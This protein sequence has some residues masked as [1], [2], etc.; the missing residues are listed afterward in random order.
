MP[1]FK[2][3][4]FRFD[5]TL[6]DGVTPPEDT[7]SAPE[8]GGAS[9]GRAREGASRHERLKRLFLVPVASAIAAV[10]IIFASLGSDPLGNDFLNKP[11]SS[12]VTPTT[13][14]TPTPTPPKPS[15]DT[16]PPETEK[17]PD[18]Y[19]DSF[20]AIVNADPDFA[21][22]FAWAGMGS[23]E[24]LIVDGN[25]LHAGTYYSTSGVD[26]VGAIPGASYDKE[27]NTLTLTD[28]H[29]SFID[30][31][32]MGNGFKIELVGDNSLDY[33]QAWGAMY[34][35]S[36]TFTGE[37]SIT[38]N[39]NKTAVSGIN[40]NCEGSPSRL[41][42]DRGVTLD[43]YGSPA[44]SINDSTVDDT[45]VYLKPIVMSGDTNGERVTF[46]PGE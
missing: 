44:L 9:G 23:E 3:N 14:V 35:G 7:L 34:G 21:G 37:G 20:P 42:I 13:P 11:S 1:A 12:V 24:Y 5:P 41:M 26:I 2:D 46:A 25:F 19:D 16:E 10:S 15:T 30:A 8:F 33:V 43:V 39:E 6:E 22:D 17:T 18:E 40:L 27:T 38:L 45:V 36:V 29:G 28:Y 32:L 31:N 4:E